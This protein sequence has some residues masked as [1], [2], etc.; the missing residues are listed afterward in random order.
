MGACPPPGGLAQQVVRV[1]HRN[2]RGQRERLLLGG[3]SGSR[4]DGRTRVHEVLPDHVH[5]VILEFAA[6]QLLLAEPSGH[7]GERLG[8]VGD[9]EFDDA[10]AC[11][12]FGGHGGFLRFG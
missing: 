3:G 2:G 10:A 9:A 11:V 5:E 7:G 4:G 12:V 8:V 6:Q 1:I